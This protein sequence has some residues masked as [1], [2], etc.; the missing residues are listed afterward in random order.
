MR[1][2]ADR[3]YT[4]EQVREL[5][6]RAIEDHGIRGYDLM[7]R[8]A[9]AAFRLLRL[10]WPRARRIAVYCGGGNNGGD[11]LVVARLAREAGFTVE[12]CR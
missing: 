2:Q 10:R 5:D 11:G 8:A 12:S 3:L 4:A 6:R 1:I 7:V 9:R